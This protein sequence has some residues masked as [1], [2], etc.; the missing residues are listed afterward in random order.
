M[1]RLVEYICS[2]SRAILASNF[3]PELF[4]AI[5]DQNVSTFASIL[6]RKHFPLHQIFEWKEKKTILLVIA[7]QVDI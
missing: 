5:T 6:W 4:A 1:T 2:E 7:I 3:E